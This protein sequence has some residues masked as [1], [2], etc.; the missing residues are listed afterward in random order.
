MS[1]KVRRLVPTVFLSLL[2]AGTAMPTLAA[3]PKQCGR[4][5]HRIRSRRGETFGGG[6][7]Q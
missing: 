6:H 1:I 4:Q 5:Q 7:P 2:L 3:A